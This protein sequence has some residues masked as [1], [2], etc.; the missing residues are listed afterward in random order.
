MHSKEVLVTLSSEH[1]EVEIEGQSSEKLLVIESLPVRI[2]LSGFNGTEFELLPLSSAVQ[3]AAGLL[4]GGSA[5]LSA[6]PL[7]GL[8]Q[9]IGRTLRLRVVC[10][11]LTLRIRPTP[12][13]A[14]DPL[15]LSIMVML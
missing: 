3:S 6:V 12:S 11:S 13:T 14:E 5:Q 7:A 10:P 9:G 15:D 1:L 8:S 4:L 2:G